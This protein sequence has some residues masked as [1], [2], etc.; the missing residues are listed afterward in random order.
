MSGHYL[1]C[2]VGHDGAWL[3]CPFQQHLLEKKPREGGGGG[4]TQV[5][6]EYPPLNGY[7]ER[8]G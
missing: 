4:G 5:Q 7:A 1:L 3:F 2:K 6:N 8:K